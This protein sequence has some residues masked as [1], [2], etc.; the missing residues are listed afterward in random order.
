ME[1]L[2]LVKCC[3]SSQCSVISDIILHIRVNGFNMTKSDAR[4]NRMDDYHF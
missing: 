2:H 1:L 3:K 4:P